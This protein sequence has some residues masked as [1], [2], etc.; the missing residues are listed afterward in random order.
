MS[1]IPLEL[2]VAILVTPC[3]KVIVLSYAFAKF[4]MILP[5]WSTNRTKVPFFA[6]ARKRVVAFS[7]VDGWVFLKLG[8]PPI[9]ANF[10]NFMPARLCSGNQR[11]ELP[12]PFLVARL[13][14]MIIRICATDCKDK[15]NVFRN[16]SEFF[17]NKCHFLAIIAV[18]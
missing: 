5:R 7:S 18:D 11:Q 10:A 14:A 16:S 8:A 12:H 1:E 4:N 3:H 2:K 15:C 17:L 6:G 9:F 13:P